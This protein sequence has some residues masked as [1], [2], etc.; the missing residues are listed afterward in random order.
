MP[1]SLQLAK[2]QDSLEVASAKTKI[3][4]MDTLSQDT[5]SIV[6]LRHSPTKAALL[7]AVLPGLGQIY[8]KK[9]WKLPILYAGL[10][11][12]AYFLIDNQR[13]YKKYYD[14]W[15][16]YSNTK[17]INAVKDFSLINQP[18]IIDAGRIDE[19]FKFYVTQF[20]QNRDWSFVFVAG[21]YV[22]GIVDAAVDAYLFDYDISDDLTMKANPTII[23]SIG[24][25][26]TVGLTLSF[27]L[28]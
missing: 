28:H 25:K 21:F 14:G 19:A 18:G 27:N 20:R 17:D 15:V 7:S 3:I 1:L 11:I 4:N 12:S 26:N 8:N 6:V 16:N 24:G 22:L 10:S 5:S 9:F 13:I 23:K 2:S